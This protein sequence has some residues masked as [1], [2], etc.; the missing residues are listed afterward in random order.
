MPE[1]LDFSAIIA[2]CMTWGVWGKDWDVRQA[3]SYIDQLLEAGVHTFDHADIYGDYT[4]EGLFGEALAASSTSRD[5]IRL[6]SKC[7]IQITGGRENRV[8]HYQYDRQYILDSVHRSLGA[9]RTDRL[10]LL[11]LHRPSPLLVADEVAEAIELLRKEGK[12]LHFGVSNFTPAQTALLERAVPVEANQFEFSI[13]AIDALYD[14]VL[15]D[16]QAFGRL[17]M[18]WSPLGTILR[19]RR[20]DREERILKTMEGLKE[21]YETDEAGLAVM[22]ISRHPAGILPVVGSTRIDRVRVMVEAVR[23]EMELQDWFS[24]WEASLGRRVP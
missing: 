9:L 23:K 5:S 13:S 4:T 11:L 20:E 8:K 14:G 21:K 24:L 2:G 17:P 7:G 1:K 18:A 10:D 16:C 6:I 3:T 12:I 22:W 15:E 19:Q